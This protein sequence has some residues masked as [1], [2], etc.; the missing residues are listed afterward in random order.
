MQADQPVANSAAEFMPILDLL[1][2][3]FV[4]RYQHRQIKAVKHHLITLGACH[5]PPQNRH[6]DHENVQRPVH[7]L[8]KRGLPM[9]RGGEDLRCR[10]QA[11]GE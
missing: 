5:Q 10:A 6:R 2:Q 8:R 7:Q 3:R 11:A 9:R 4:F 1:G